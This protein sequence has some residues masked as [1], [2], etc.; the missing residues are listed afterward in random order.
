MT[1]LSLCTILRDDAA[2]IERCLRSA[3]EVCD[4]LCVLDTGSTDGGERVAASFGARVGR[5][6]WTDDFA[7]ARNRSLELASGDWLLVLDS[8]EALAGDPREVRTALERFA[9]SHPDHA[10]RLRIENLQD[11]GGS[12]FVSLARFFPRV[13]N[14]CYFGRIHEQW[15]LV[16]GGRAVLPPRADTGVSAVHHGYLAGAIASR[17]KLARNRAL[18]EL[19]A[20]ER[21]DDAYVHYQLGRTLAMASE[22]EA[23]VAS[24]ERALAL[25]DDA[26][27]WAIHAVELGAQGLRELGRGQ[28]AL[29]FVRGALPLAG[30]RTDTHFL[31]ASLA[32]DCGDVDGA[33]RGFRECLQLGPAP[34]SSVESWPGA[35]SWAAEHNLGVLCEHTGRPA[36][37][38]DHYARALALQPG[39]PPSLAGVARL[40]AALPTDGAIR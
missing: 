5:A 38:R 31:A 28:L 6:A 37:A 33:E 2:G 13:P 29:D 36:E 8:D 25:C 15:M 9:S 24:L 18:L 32:L 12:S 23:A 39:Y 16:R 22:H 4:E 11:G 3:R 34:A 17:G 35:G 14:G 10:G 26:D 27:D 7:A 40:D 1:R 20:R 21:P 19:E 30:C